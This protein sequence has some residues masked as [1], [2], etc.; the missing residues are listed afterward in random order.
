M[1]D[2]DT[3]KTVWQRLDHFIQSELDLKL[4]DRQLRALHAYV[5]AERKDA[6]D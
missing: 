3:N 2:I 6:R 4:D 5:V 1:I